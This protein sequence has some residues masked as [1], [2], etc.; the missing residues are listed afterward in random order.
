MGNEIIGCDLFATNELFKYSY[1]SLIHSY[2]GN[3]ITKG[4]SVVMASTQV[5]SYLDKILKSEYD[6]DKNIEK[7]DTIYK[8]KEKNHI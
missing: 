3:A 8:W 6:Q 4:A 7:N 2:I 5:F 1:K